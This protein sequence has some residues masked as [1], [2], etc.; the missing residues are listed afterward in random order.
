MTFRSSDDIY[1]F[2]EPFY[3]T[4]RKMKISISENAEKIRQ[5][6]KINNILKEKITNISEKNLALKGLLNQLIKGKMSPQKKTLIKDNL[7][8]RNNNIKEKNKRLKEKINS[9]NQKAL[10]LQKK[11]EKEVKNLYKDLNLLQ[12]DSFILSNQIDFK[13]NIIELYKERLKN[14]NC[15]QERIRENYIDKN[16]REEC[17]HFF[18][19]K[20]LEFQ[21]KLQIK[22]KQLNKEK[23]KIKDLKIKI[24][25]IK[26]NLK[27][28]KSS[29]K[30][31]SDKKI[32]WETERENEI[33]NNS[34]E[35][36]SLIFRDFELSLNTLS[37][38][39]EKRFNKQNNMNL[40][41]VILNIPDKIHMK[42]MKMNIKKKMLR[43]MKEK[44]NSSLNSFD[45]SNFCSI[46]HQ[47]N[48][49]LVPKLNLKQIEF[50]K[51][52]N[53][54][55]F[56]KSFSKISSTLTSKS[57]ENRIN[58]ELNNSIIDK[59]I[60]K[61]QS[62]INE[63]KKKV[64]KNKKLIKDFKIFSKEYLNNYDLSFFFKNNN[65]NILYSEININNN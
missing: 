52:Y 25:S 48:S 11:L 35:D 16:S 29:K 40:S 22:L 61:M 51:I 42:P 7:E 62:K 57:V 8:Q 3:T 60:E 41:P 45:D 21:N 59:K 39:F 4:K 30:L 20:S 24:N 32:V 12:D 23:N 27:L 17:D 65:N 5:L 6:F 38:S 13:N 55:N 49:N 10:K 58:K 1:L 19:K 2:D 33:D 9:E 26:S 14:F 50:N 37:E 36:K 28:F 31:I 53:E 56:Q 44:N 46:S 47:K 15:I 64:F 34:E 54:T 43:K 18:S 63:L